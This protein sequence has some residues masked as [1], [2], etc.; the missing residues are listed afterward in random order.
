MGIETLVIVLVWIS[1]S[2]VLSIHH[3]I[4]QW[5]YLGLVIQRVFLKPSI[6][7]EFVRSGEFRSALLI[8]IDR[9]DLSGL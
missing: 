7:V 2:S 6:K 8:H 9:Q 4:H 5:N 1:V 3:G